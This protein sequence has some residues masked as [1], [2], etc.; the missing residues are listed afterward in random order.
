MMRR[1]FCV[2]G[3]LSHLSSFQKQ[4][5][6]ARLV[7]YELTTPEDG[8][9]DF[10]HE[11][12]FRDVEADLHSVVEVLGEHGRGVVDVIDHSQWQMTRYFLEHGR[13]RSVPIYL[14][15]ALDTAYRSEMR[16]P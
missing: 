12:P 14:D 15:H 6:A 11:G 9:L 13:L 2:Y 7:G 16:D 5:I 8:T 3:H 10:V 1:D 4:Q